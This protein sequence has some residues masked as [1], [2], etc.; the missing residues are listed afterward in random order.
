MPILEHSILELALRKNFYVLHNKKDTWIFLDLIFSS[1][2]FEIKHILVNYSVQSLKRA[3]TTPTSQ[4]LFKLLLQNKSPSASFFPYI[5]LIHSSFHLFPY[6]A[7]FLSDVWFSLICTVACLLWFSIKI[8]HN[9]Y[10]YHYYYYWI[11]VPDSAED[12]FCTQGWRRVIS[13]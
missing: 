12:E 1:V 9:H 2:K 13:A 7:L 6:R 10:H 8:K 11:Y 4:A 3:L 5:T